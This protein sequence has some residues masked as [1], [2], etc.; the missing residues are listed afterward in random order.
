[1]ASIAIIEPSRGKHNCEKAEFLCLGAEDS[2]SSPA[3]PTV[4]GIDDG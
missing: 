4:S 1:M 2:R 3:L